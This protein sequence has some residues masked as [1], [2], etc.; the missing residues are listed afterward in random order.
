MTLAAGA[1]LIAS[2]TRRPEKENRRPAFL[3]DDDLFAFSDAAEKTG[4]M[5]LASWKLTTPMGHLLACGRL[6]CARAISGNLQRALGWERDHL[7][8]ALPFLLLE[9]L[10]N[11]SQVIVET[12]RMLLANFSDLLDDRIVPHET[13]VYLRGAELFWGGRSSRESCQPMARA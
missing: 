7:P 11:L 5:G 1:R 9:I 6:P 8:I 4:E 3:R 12:S 13:H 2:G 10:E